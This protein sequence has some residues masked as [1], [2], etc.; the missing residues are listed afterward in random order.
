[1]FICSAKPLRSYLP[2]DFIK[3]YINKLILLYYIYGL[4][5]ELKLLG[6]MQPYN[7]FRPSYDNND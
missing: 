2:A 6:L 5:K 4:I 1:M 7:D 3:R